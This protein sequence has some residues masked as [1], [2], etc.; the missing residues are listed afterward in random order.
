MVQL[1]YKTPNYFYW[2]ICMVSLWSHVYCWILK[3]WE[4]KSSTP[5]PFLLVKIHL[6]KKFKMTGIKENFK[7][8]G[9]LYAYHL[10][11]KKKRKHTPRNIRHSLI[12]TQAKR[13][14]S[15]CCLVLRHRHT[16]EDTLTPWDGCQLSSAKLNFLTL[17]TKIG[18]SINLL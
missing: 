13:P 10:T 12:I 7:Q 15:Y 5:S 3:Y 8:A 11:K 17:G 4:E 1:I 16:L 14:E 2:P 9:F 18:I 6:I